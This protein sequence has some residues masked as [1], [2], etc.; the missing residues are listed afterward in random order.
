VTLSETRTEIVTPSTSDPM[1]FALSPDGRQIV[2]VGTGEG[3]TRLWVRALSSTTARPLPGTEDAASPFWSPDS[4]SI[5]FVAEGR[6]KRLDLSGGAPMVLAPAFARGGTWNEQ[7]EILFVAGTGTAVFRV[8]AAGGLPQQVTRL[9]GQ[10]SHR[11]PQFLPDGRLFLF[12]ALGGP[13][14]TGIYLGSLDSDVVTRL[15][16]S[17]SFGQLLPSGWLLWVRAGA[18]VAQRIELSQGTLAGTPMT[19]ADSVG[20]DTVNGTAAF[21]TSRSGLIAY[22]SSDS[23]R[24]QLRWF[25]RSGKPLGAFGEPDEAGLSTV[26][27][28]PDGRRAVVFRTLEGNTDIWSLD[29]ARMTRLTFAQG[30]DRYPVFSRDGARFMFD[31]AREQSRDLY[32]GRIDSP[33]TETPVLSSPENKSPGDWSH[34]ERFHVYH[35]IESQIGDWDLWILPFDESGAPGKPW[36]FLTSDF[37]ERAPSVSPDGRWVA[38]QSDQSG[39]HEVYVRVFPT[40]GAADSAARA[41]SPSSGQWQVSTSGGIRPTWRADGRELY[42]IDPGGRLMAASVVTS[43]ATFEAGTP[44]PLFAT[45][46]VGSGVEN[47]QGRQYDVSRDGRFLVNTVLDEAAAPITILQNWSSPV[48]SP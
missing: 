43:G 42:Y 45:Q 5:A 14:S 48:A 19:I 36:P 3:R 37:E 1:S 27:L 6:L 16:P 17:V 34:D 4:R 35:V 13:D 47:G 15:T 8:A 24:R 23:N 25:D 32:V 18:L 26:R 39:R 10:S 11:W 20:L 41:A 9:A 40:S 33:G 2:F 46:I 31:S 21:S 7:G 12:W 38:Y 22:R 30:L 44:V 28:S 29:G